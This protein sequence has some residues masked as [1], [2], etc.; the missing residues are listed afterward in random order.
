MLTQQSTTEIMAKLAIQYLSPRKESLF[1]NGSRDRIIIGCGVAKEFQISY[2]NSNVCTQSGSDDLNCVSESL[3]SFF[4]RNNGEYI[5][6]YT[7]FDLQDLKHSDQ[8]PILKCI[9]PRLVIE[10]TSCGIRKLAGFDTNGILKNLDHIISLDRQVGSRTNDFLLIDPIEHD[11]LSFDKF[12]ANFDAVKEMIDNDS[13]SR[14]TIARKIYLPDSVS[15][16]GSFLQRPMSGVEGERVYLWQERDLQFVGT[17]PELLA[18][19]TV[20]SFKTYKLSGTAPRYSDIEF[21][22]YQE[23]QFI[24]DEKIRFEHQSSIKG[25]NYSLA[26]L[27]L[28]SHSAPI[29]IN[30]YNLRHLMTKFTTVPTSNVS[31]SEILINILPNGASPHENG[32]KLIRLLE[33]ERRGGVRVTF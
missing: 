27:G 2:D 18:V 24:K 23:Q 14:L 29:V 10:V 15:L 16:S 11:N 1:A 5:F 9:V 17:N 6:C 12:T 22:S 7:T 3:N 8:S 4:S 19:G 33:S 21:D 26:K 30:W 25:M 32:M 20:D 31:I 13:I 28:V